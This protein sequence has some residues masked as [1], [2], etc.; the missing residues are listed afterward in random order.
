MLA[1]AA[2]K[3]ALRHHAVAQD[4][5][6]SGRHPTAIVSLTVAWRPTV[7][8][9]LSTQGTRGDVQ[10]FVALAR[11]LQLRGHVVALC[12][13]E[14]FRQLVERHGVSYAHMDNAVLELTQAVLSARSAR[15][16]RRLFRGFAPIIRRTLDDEWKAAQALRP[17]VVVY[18][19][20]ALG[21]HHIAEKLG[22]AE[23][24]AM[25]LP[26]TPT[27][28]F[29]VP[30]LPDFG[31]GGWFNL[32]SYRLVT[33]GQAL[34]AGSTND[35]RVST[36]G[37][38]PLSRFVDTTHSRV[39]GQPI[40]SLYGF[41]ESVLAKP[42]D[43]PEHAHVTGCWFL[44]DAGQEPL[45]PALQRFIEAGAPPVYVGFGSMVG[46]HASARTEAVINGVLLAGQRA[47]I[48]TGWGGLI[49][50][51]ASSDVFELDAAPHDLLFPMMSAVV[52]H[53]GAGTTMACLRA[54][55]PAVICAFIGDQA[56]WG[57]VVARAG[58]GAPPLPQKGLTA[59]LLA[60]SIL[61]AIG[62]ESSAR[63]SAIKNRMLEEDGVGNAV[64]I[65]ERTV[66]G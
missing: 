55:K 39:S 38:R 35:F 47:V 32:F 22:I 12:A 15:E 18:H 25:P 56:F 48:A 17:D 19:S 53:G 42:P 24:L 6:W 37:L 8:V 26:L 44:D 14:G 63:A 66:S 20:K 7:R 2:P 43:W 29:P 4:F 62:P 21:A 34:W 52:H 5:R 11:A 40:P 45:P 28:A 64:A 49:H 54:G 3:G 33:L 57:R 10:P 23:F 60:T 13:P 59:E 31:L 9:L 65:I 30:L 58:A 36:L 27:R 51:E 61:Q 41:S 50:R 46:A 1:G 16:Q